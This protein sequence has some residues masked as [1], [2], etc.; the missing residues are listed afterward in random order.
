MKPPI[1]HGTYNECPECGDC[2]C[3]YS[4][5]GG[6]FGDLN[7]TCG[8]YTQWEEHQ[9]TC[10]GCEECT[11]KPKEKKPVL[12]PGLIVLGKE[13]INKNGKFKAY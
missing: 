6:P 2:L 3:D 1:E 7:C 9:E 11:P 10:N 5:E 12:M 8:Y 4:H 13:Q